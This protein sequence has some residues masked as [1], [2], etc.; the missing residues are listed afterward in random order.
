MVQYVR[1]ALTTVSELSEPPALRRQTA[2]ALERI[3]TNLV[4]AIIFT[5]LYFKHPSYR[6][7]REYRF[8]MMT[9]PDNTIPGLLMRQSNGQSVGYFPFDWKTGHSRCLT[10]VCI[11]P[12]I[13]GA[14]G[15]RI[16]SEVLAPNSLSAEIIRTT[17]PPT[18]L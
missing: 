18:V 13:D 12:A 6:S 9:L 15:R 5:S 11:G 2:R 3:A 17:I 8:L 14:D 16:A 4:F 7:E 1:N 10:S